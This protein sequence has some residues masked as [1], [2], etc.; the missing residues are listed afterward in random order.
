MTTQR[1]IRVLF[2]YGNDPSPT[3]LERMRVLED[4]GEFEPY[5]ITWERG[6]S[7]IQI[8]WSSDLPS[9][10]FIR[11]S[12][13]D[14]RG[15]L[16]RRAYLTFKF[17]KAVR[18][19]VKS[20]RAD[21]IDSIYPDMLVSARA[22][23]LGVKRRSLVY[24]LWDLHGKRGAGVLARWF[25]RRLFGSVDL[26]F[27]S[28]EGYDTQFLS[29]HRLLTP[30]TSVVYVPNCPL[31][32]NFRREGPAPAQITI[33]YVGQ[34]RI[35]NEIANLIEAIR[36]ARDRGGNLR[37]FV[38][39]AGRESAWLASEAQTQDFIDYLGPF[40]YGAEIESIFA[41]CDI[42]FA[43][44]PQDELN[45]RVHWARRS[46][47]SLVSGIPM[48]VARGS[49]MGDYVA[50]NGAGWEVAYDSQAELTELLERLAND[51]S[52][53]E[54]ASTAAIGISES[55]RLESYSQ[56]IVDAYRSLPLDR[57]RLCRG[58]G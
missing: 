11:V 43:V 24:D 8:P 21:V 48:I 26:M 18:R 19:A 54:Q 49:Q 14:P 23:M 6:G 17:T 46:H 37:L 5:A 57:D 31:G 22:A 15:N 36:T 58:D 35:R 52:L 53:V 44:Y 47:Q 39:G 10:R 40:D 38:A 41:R 56:R 29:L 13:P 33:G 1:K 7:N 25:W 42:M 55:H 4:S 27:M 32:W 28:S 16:V 12:L 3:L 34:I 9:E 30:R 20:T 45:Y 50:A 51:R 2:V